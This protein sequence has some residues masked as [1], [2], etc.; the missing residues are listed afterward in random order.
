M[1]I[2][3][4][5]TLT[6]S[7]IHAQRSTGRATSGRAS[8]VKIPI[9]KLPN[10]INMAEN[11]P[12]LPL[13]FSLLLLPEFGPLTIA[14]EASNV[15]MVGWWVSLSFPAPS[16]VSRTPGPAPPTA[17]LLGRGRPGSRDKGD[18]PKTGSE[19]L[20]RQVLLPPQTTL[21]WTKCCQDHQHNASSVDASSR[22]HSSSHHKPGHRWGPLLPCAD[23]FSCQVTCSV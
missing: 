20:W 9:I 3:T 17:C 7:F 2:H 23:L 4:L 6:P 19:P 18:S 21:C 10:L 1:C 22:P 14:V 11:L 13:C 15:G 16:Q 12:W 8:H 5:H